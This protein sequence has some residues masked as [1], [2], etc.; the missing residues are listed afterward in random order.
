MELNQNYKF[1]VDNYSLSRDVEEGETLY[2]GEGLNYKAGKGNALD[3][4]FLDGSRHM[5]SY[6][7]MIY[8]RLER[9]N[10]Q[11]VI[12]LFQTTHMVLIKGYRLDF[13]YEKIIEQNLKFVKESAPI[14]ISLAD[15][16]EPFINAIEIE[17]RS[18]QTT[19]DE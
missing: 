12:K 11:Q 3:L 1:K 4:Q 15:E 13:L 9:E 5:A 7:H 16:N 19:D 2:F 14:E 6:N 10:N 8:A 17:W 18:N